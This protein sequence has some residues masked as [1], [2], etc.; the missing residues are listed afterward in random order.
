MPAFSISWFD[1]IAPSW[2]STCWCTVMSVSTSAPFATRPS[3][4]WVIYSSMLGCTRVGTGSWHWLLLMHKGRYRVM[5]LTCADAH[6]DRYRVM[7]LTCDDAH[8][9]RYRV[10]TLTCDDAHM[11][12]YR[13]VSYTHL[14]LP[15]ICS[16]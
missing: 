7:T 12:R 5:T 3:N 6:M 8:M 1:R 14:T 4:S 9:D 13:A 15:T 10:M 2:A 11:E 16:V